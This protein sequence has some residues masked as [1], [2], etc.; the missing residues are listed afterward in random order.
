MLRAFLTILLLLGAVGFAGCS[1]GPADAPDDDSDA[2]GG[3]QTHPK[4][5]AVVLHDQTAQD[6]PTGENPFVADFDVEAPYDQIVIVL[7]AS[8]V[9]QYRLVVA[10]PGG[11]AVYD[12]GDQASATE[13]DSHSHAAQGVPVATTPGAHTAE[14]SFTGGITYHLTIFASK[15]GAE[16]D[17]PH[18]H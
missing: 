10:G 7:H 3:N 9:G 13:P 5:K 8:G 15:T 16:A 18:D 4:P 11:E 14:L 1:S 17:E 2:G 6:I 12:T